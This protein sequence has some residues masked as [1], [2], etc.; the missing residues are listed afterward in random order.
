MQTGASSPVGVVAVC[1][2]PLGSSRL[3]AEEKPFPRELESI[4]KSENKAVV[5]SNCLQSHVDASARVA[6]ETL[7]RC[8]PVDYRSRFMEKERFPISGAKARRFL[9]HTSAFV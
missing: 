4:L 9:S 6:D 1:W 5:V 8:F 2:K 3:L 7:L